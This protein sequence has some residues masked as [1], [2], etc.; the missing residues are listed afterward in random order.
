MPVSRQDAATMLCRIIKATAD[1]S[2]I[3]KLYSDYEDVSDYARDAVAALS[4]LGI[5]NGMADSKFCPALYCT[6]AQAAKM[7]YETLRRE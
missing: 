3:S 2:D 5:V 7:I 4:K 1:K 6:R